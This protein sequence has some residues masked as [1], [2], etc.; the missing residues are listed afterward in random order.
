MEW[1]NEVGAFAD[2][3]SPIQK[4]TYVVAAAGALLGLLGGLAVLVIRTR[5]GLIELATALRVKRFHDRAHTA[6]LTPD[7]TK[8]DIR[9]ALRGYVIPDCAATDP[10]NADEIHRVAAIR[11]PVMQAVDEFVAKS[12]NTHLLVLADTGMGKTTFC[13][14]YFDRINKLSEKKEG[15]LCAVIPLGRPDTVSKIRAIASKNDTVLILDALDEDVEAMEDAPSRLSVLMSEAASF[16]HVI[17]TCRSQF[18]RDDASIPHRTGVRIVRPRKGG[19]VG[20]YVFRTMYLL[21]FDE[22]QIEAYVR[23]QFP[24]SRWGSIKK[25]KRAYE[26]IA[27]IPELS[28]RPMLLA[29]LPD[30][31]KEQAEITELYDL[32]DYMITKW[33]ERESHWIKPEYLIAVSKSLAVYIY[34]SRKNRRSERVTLEEL[35]DIARIVG[36]PEDV[37]GH[38]SA[39]SLLNRD[40]EGGIK[41]SHRSIMEFFFVQSAI[42]GDERCFDG[43]WTDFMRDLFVSWGN[44]EAGEKGVERAKEILKLDLE[45]IGLSPLSQPLAGP[46]DYTARAYVQRSR[47]T[48]RRIASSWRSHSIKLMTASGQR[49]LQ[50][51]EYGLVWAVPPASDYGDPSVRAMPHLQAMKSPVAEGLASRDQFLSLLEAEY[52]TGTDL[53]PRDTYLWLGDT[54]GGQPVVVSVSSQSFELPGARLLGSFDMKDRH[55]VPVWAYAVETRPRRFAE[56]VPQLT[57]IPTMVSEID[58]QTGQRIHRM[59]EDELLEY[60]ESVFKRNLD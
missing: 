1:L 6:G 22:R 59:S 48:G 40:S 29:M 9:S 56:K 35:H 14:N 50:D 47:E 12:K 55:G 8:D 18:F 52:T 46:A 3:L 13:L 17:V 26:I 41:F 49:V 37:W 30:L 39:R 24:L 2:G 53:L 25:R 4:V 16:R 27:D 57:A 23:T 54:V 5:A 44:T 34:G 58:W 60:L 21:P 51:D 32:Y 28:V 19:L 15:P 20:E 11:Q 38:L 45:S 7:F 10:S 43:Y 31:V 36:A 33:L 42:D